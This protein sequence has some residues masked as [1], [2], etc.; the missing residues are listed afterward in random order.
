MEDK[1]FNQELIVKYLLGDL[2]EQEQARIE[3]RAI[4]DHRY[5][6]NI[7][8]VESDLI[9][10]YVR[11][12]LSAHE[13]RQFEGRFLASQERQQK[14][15]FARALA[16]VAPELAATDEGVARRGVARLPVPW[17]E[18]FVALIGGARPAARFSLAAASLLLVIGISWLAAQTIRLRGELS[19]LNAEQQAQRQQQEDLERQAAREHARS[20]ELA[21]QLQREQQQ[22]EQSEELARQ[23]QQEQERLARSQ[24]E[25][26]R[27]AAPTTIASLIL[28]PGTSRGAQGRP[29]LIVPRAA[30][31]AR[32]Q[33]G[34]ERGD[35]YK[36]FRVEL[37]SR[38]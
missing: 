25:E 13:R 10:E 28:L 5:L 11:G 14:V 4:S 31:L 38:A 34:L 33:I 29:Q 27:P 37:S 35:E 9:D 36:S 12:G 6:R 32:L 20:E 17:W 21:A 2:P 30:R 26:A 7:Q 22:R 24:K 1:S 23:L 19:R 3:D 8:A 15:E 18:S 16:K